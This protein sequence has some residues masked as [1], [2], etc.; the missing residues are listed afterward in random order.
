[1]VTTTGLIISSALNLAALLLWIRL[2]SPA[3][4]GLLALATSAGQLLNALA[5]EWLRLAGARSLADPR[6][7]D[8][9]D[10]R[11]LAAWLRI[12]AIAAVLVVAALL[13]A[14]VV[15]V[16]PPGLSPR[17]NI[18]I[19]LLAASEMLLAAITLVARLRLRA[20]S[21]AA[22]MVGRSALALGLGVVVVRQG[23]GAAGIIAA[24]AL[25]QLAVTAIAVAADP[26][27]RTAVLIRSSP[28]DRADLVRLGMP[29]IAASGLALAAATIDRTLVAQALG[30]AAAGQFAAPAEIVAK[31][32]G[33]ALMAANLSAYPLL[34]RS[35]ERDGPAAAARALDRNLVVLLAAGVPIA[36]GL[37]VLASPLAALLF[38]PA[39]APLAARLLPWLAG[40]ALVRLL[41]TFHFG[42]ALQL[43]RR[44]GLLIIP[45]LMTLAILVP[46]AA[47]VIAAAGLEGFCKL[48]LASQVAG[49][50]TAWALARHAFALAYASDSA[51]SP[52]TSRPAPITV[53]STSTTA[54]SSVAPQ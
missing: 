46:L 10:P 20:A 50:L 4:F 3:Q 40:A 33:F 31:T 52:M 27:W 2:L 24:T 7:P 8:G 49:A 45:S 48:L 37:T 25:A 29:L 32:L 51:A 38:N 39:A 16:A 47:P 35:W 22:A 34:V 54:P 17:W 36:T 28:G 18:A 6:A 21:Y 1:M 41:V 26:L 11:I 30:V 9:V 15:R 42:V 44:M 43:A 14:T 12:A 19:L 13:A 23:A 53:R 5:F